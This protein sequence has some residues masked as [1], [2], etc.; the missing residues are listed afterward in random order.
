MGARRRA[1]FTRLGILISIIFLFLF[2]RDIDIEETGIALRQANYLWL[3]PCFLAAY[4]SLLGRAYRW[5]VFLGQQHVKIGIPRLFNTLT[6]GFFGNTVLPARAGEFVRAYMLARS[7]P[8]RFTEAFATVVVERVFDL[9]A[10]IFSIVLLFVI[11]P[12]PQDVVESRPELFENLKYFGYF[13]AVVTFSFA[14]FLAVMVRMPRLCHR[15]LTR[16]TAWLPGHLQ[17]RVLHALESFLSG[18]NTFS[19]LTAILKAL[20]WTAAVWFCILLTEYFTI[21]AFGF[22][23]SLLNTMVLMVLLAFAVAVPQAPG[24]LGPFHFASE[25]TLVGFFS[26]AP[27][28][29]KAFAVVL[30]FAQ[31]FPIFVIGL[32]CLHLEGLTIRQL[33]RSV[34]VQET[35]QDESVALD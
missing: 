16:L 23:I 5:R 35:Q 22:P 1:W 17:E 26:V 7:E 29:A 28:E 18:L 9:F 19:N 10:L 12:F 24:Y 27:A 8:V 4:G 25:Q 32:V 2:F 3:I 11:A 14:A 15:I 21:L 31:L 34:K 33:W 20:G 6:I 30:W 13:S